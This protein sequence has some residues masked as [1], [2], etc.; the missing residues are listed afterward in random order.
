MR[1]FAGAL[2]FFY[3]GWAESASIRFPDEELA[4]ESVLPLVDLN[5]PQM[6]LNRRVPLK[7]RVEMGLGG[8]FGLDEPFYFPFYGSGILGFHITETHSV[9]FIG[10]YFPP[11]LSNDGKIL[12]E[13][14]VARQTETGEEET[15]YLKALNAPHPQM[16][17]FLNYQYSPSYGKISLTKS[18][19][20]NMSLYGFAGPGFLVFDQGN[21]TWAGNIGIGQK[22][23]FNRWLGIRGDLGFYGYFGPAPTKMNLNGEAK[24]PFDKV[25]ADEK[26]LLIN[27]IAY[28]GIVLLI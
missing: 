24:I 28:V 21:R 8:A 5:P 22:L 1:F 6:V 26:R 20:M 12:S 2:I 3:M 10:T 15:W 18:G 14:G 25:K 4:S 7:Y 23:Y 17:V 16:M 13:Q 19:V 11:L 9:H 27:V